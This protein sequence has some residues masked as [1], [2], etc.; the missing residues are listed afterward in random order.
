MPFQPAPLWLQT[1]LINRHYATAAV[2]EEV[3][4]AV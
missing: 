1:D 4:A 2:P 3:V